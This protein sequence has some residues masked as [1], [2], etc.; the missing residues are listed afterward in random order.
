MLEDGIKSKELGK[1]HPIKAAKY[2][3][4]KTSKHSGKQMWLCPEDD[5]AEEGFTGIAFLP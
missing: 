4:G 5:G 3:W 2:S 1:Q